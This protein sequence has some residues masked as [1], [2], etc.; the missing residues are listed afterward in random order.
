M[1]R[2]AQDTKQNHSFLL[3]IFDPLDGLDVANQSITLLG[4]QAPNLHRRLRVPL[5]HDS[6]HISPRSPYIRLLIK[7]SSA[8]GN[9]PNVLTRLAQLSDI[10]ATL[11]F[12]EPYTTIIST[13]H[14]ELIVELQRGDR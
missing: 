12:P 2:I 11:N 10:T 1:A 4:P 7:T 14:Q 9:L 13:S 8:K 6:K 3:S 5:A